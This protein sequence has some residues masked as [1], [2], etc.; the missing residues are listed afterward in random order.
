MG[1]ITQ[2]RSVLRLGTLYK[3]GEGMGVRLHELRR[4]FKSIEVTSRNADMLRAR[5]TGEKRAPLAGEWYFSGS[6]I[7]AYQAS[8]DLTLVYCIAQIV[9]TKEVVTVEIVEAAQ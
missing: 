1:S 2:D 7:E 6:E 4:S 5:W 9:F 8:A 3:L